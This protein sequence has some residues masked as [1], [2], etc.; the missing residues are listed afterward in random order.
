MNIDQILKI[1]APFIAFL[2]FLLYFLGDVYNSN[3]LSALGLESGLFQNGIEKNIEQ[4]YIQLILANVTWIFYGVIFLLV[5]FYMLIPIFKLFDMQNAKTWIDEQVEGM[6]TITKNL[7]NLQESS[8]TIALAIIIPT[9]FV[10]SLA[11]QMVA[12]A[13]KDAL[14]FKDNIKYEDIIFIEDNTSIKGKI[15]ICK[16]NHCGIYDGNKTITFPLSKIIRIEHI[17]TIDSKK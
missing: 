3:F 15:I 6:S 4:G 1:G 10:F 8:H 7:I 11:F 5:V 13:K 16:N 14:K 9:L 12:S 17:E 2:S